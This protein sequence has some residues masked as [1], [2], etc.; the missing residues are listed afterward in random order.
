M[1]VDVM[2]IYNNTYHEA[3]G[4]SPNEAFFG[5]K[6]PMQGEI[7]PISE[8]KSLTPSQYSEKLAYVLGRAEYLI[9]QFID[10]KLIKNA[11]LAPKI[12][13]TFKIND[14]VK[15]FSPRAIEGE[16]VKLTQP[17]YGPYW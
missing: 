10:E 16:S 6:M 17:Y 12:L 9:R 14:K 13:K 3:V 8:T 7:T 4:T 15:L 11:R 2:L 1:L 5:R